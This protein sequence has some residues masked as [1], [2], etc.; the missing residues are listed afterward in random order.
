ILI[1]IKLQFNSHPFILRF[2][3]LVIQSLNILLPSVPYPF[4]FCQQF[5][6]LILYCLTCTVSRF[7]LVDCPTFACTKSGRALRSNSSNSLHSFSHHISLALSVSLLRSLFR[8]RY[9]LLP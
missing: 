8:R 2:S 7:F 3:I 6:C 4:W 1:Y 5:S 9:V